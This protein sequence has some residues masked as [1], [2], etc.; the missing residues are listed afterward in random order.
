LGDNGWVT[1]KEA[2]EYWE[3]NAATWTRLARDGYDIY[4]D[5][6]N[7]PAFLAILP[8]VAGLRGIDIGCGEGHN[9]RLLARRGAAMVGLDA[10]P[11]FLRFAAGKESPMPVRY[12]LASALAI[13][14]AEGSF[15][16]AT[17]FMSLMDVPG[18]DVALRE[19]FRV[20]RPGGFLQ[21]SIVHPCFN[22]P[23]RRLL[24]DGDGMAYAVEVGRYFERPDGSVDRWIFSA[25]PAELKARLPWF[26]VPRFH[27]TLA[28]WCNAIV[29]AGFAIEHVAEPAVDDEIARRMPALQ[30]TQVVAYFL[31]VR[32]RKR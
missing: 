23:H 28:E 6:L 12:T 29:D 4:R 21:F 24:R 8:E 2:A 32:C 14:F 17:A 5:Y 25:A 18:H 26:E 27:R 20:L 3:R 13:P 9:T 15:D 22:P 10:S 7:T 31:H 19:A 1:S 11:T 30:D 16:F